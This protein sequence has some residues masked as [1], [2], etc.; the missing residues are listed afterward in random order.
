MH[1]AWPGHA[2]PSRAA[3]G[4]P[5]AVEPAA[6]LTPPV[7][8]VRGAWVAL[9]EPTLLGLDVRRQRRTARH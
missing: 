3:R 9:G 7:A 1:L 2:L 6:G 4:D 8:V 5:L